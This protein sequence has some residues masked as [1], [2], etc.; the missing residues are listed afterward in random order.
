VQHRQQQQQQQQQHLN[1][2]QDNSADSPA[3]QDAE[4]HVLIQL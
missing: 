3:L 2:L 1:K 4:N